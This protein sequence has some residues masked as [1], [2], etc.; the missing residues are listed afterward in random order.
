MTDIPENCRRQPKELARDDV[1]AAVEQD[2]E[3]ME[4]YLDRH[5]ARRG[6]AQAL[7]ALGTFGQRFRAGAVRLGLQEQGRA[8]AAGRVVDFCRRPPMCP[9]IKGVNPD[10]TTARQSEA[11]TTNEP[12]AAL[13]FKIMTDPFV[14]SLTFLRVYSGCY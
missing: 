6:N 3:A 12:F 5:R 7:H 14:G 2:D 13:A 10:E 4:A 8:A 1:E 11:P 9:A